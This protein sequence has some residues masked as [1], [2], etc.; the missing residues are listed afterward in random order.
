YSEK[1]KEEK[2]DIDEEYYRPYFEKNSVLNGFFNFL[3]KIFEVEFEKASDAKAWDKDV[4]VYNIKE[5]SKVFA[6]IYIDLE[7]KKEK[8]GGA[9]MNNW[10][11]YHRNSKGEIQLPTAYI[12]GNFP[13]S[14]EETP[15]LLRHSDVVTLFHEMGH[16]L[17]HL[18]SKIEE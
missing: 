8:R 3:N 14:T 4:L 10:H 7:A 6:R 17:H 1:L 15:S 18:L 5:N 13:Q 9:W 2:Y 16:A 11:T 12:V